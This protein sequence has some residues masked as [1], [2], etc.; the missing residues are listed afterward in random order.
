MRSFDFVGGKTR[1]RFLDS[2]AFPSKTRDFIFV[3]NRFQKQNNFVVIYKYKRRGK[4]YSQEYPGLL[5]QGENLGKQ[6]FYCWAK[7]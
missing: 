4:I 5:E 1:S 7:K 6:S 2:P 3:I